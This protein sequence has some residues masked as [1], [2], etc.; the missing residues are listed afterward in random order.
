MRK[1]IG[2]IFFAAVAIMVIGAMILLRKT[3]EVTGAVFVAR[4]G[5]LPIMVTEGGS[6]EAL[7]SQEIRSEVKGHQ[8]T[9]ILS[10][11][12]EGYL[13]TEADVKN[14]KLLVELDSSEIKQRITTQDIQFQSTV[15]SLTEAQ[16]A[17]EIQFN[18]NKTDIKAAEQKVR[19][20]RMDLEKFLGDEAIPRACS[21][22]NTGAPASAPAFSPK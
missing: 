7:E 1:H 20:A 15:A 22:L 4:Q 12:E 19:F 6:V 11:V 13:V 5:D 14:G 2:K 10:I 18:Q 9:K 16:Q 8:G 17:Y 21:R 3:E